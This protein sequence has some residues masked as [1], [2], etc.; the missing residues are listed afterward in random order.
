M[1]NIIQYILL[2]GQGVVGYE[3]SILRKDRYIVLPSSHQPAGAV[4]MRLLHLHKWSEYEPSIL[5]KYTGHHIKTVYRY[6]YVCGEH[7]EKLL[8]LSCTL[9]RRTGKWCSMCKKTPEFD[10]LLKNGYIV[11]MDIIQPRKVGRPPQIEKI[12]I[13]KELQ[14]QGFSI[15]QIAKKMASQRNSVHRW[16][17]YDTQKFDMSTK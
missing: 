1:S 14:S 11:D 12:K 2:V 8:S 10:K 3:Y 13:A 6:C 7:E 5:N 4:F 15:R 16:V 9:H 17:K